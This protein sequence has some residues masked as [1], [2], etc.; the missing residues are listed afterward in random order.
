MPST[1]ILPLTEN[2]VLTAA[3][4]LVEAFGS[5]RTRE[6][7]AAFAADATFVFHTEQNRLEARSE[8]ETLWNSW[9]A[10]GWKVSA[11]ES[12]DA[13]VQ[14]IGDSAVFSH[15]VRTT[16]GV[17]GAEE[18]TLERETIVFARFGDRILAVHE[19]LSGLPALPEVPASSDAGTS[20]AVS[21]TNSRSGAD[22]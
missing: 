22:A 18:T 20:D 15:T 12:T 9:L 6:Y 8:Y 4:E 3:A 21:A 11:C 13:R 7:F 14:L 16:A 17:P 19:H 5:T 1:P 2:E 10:E